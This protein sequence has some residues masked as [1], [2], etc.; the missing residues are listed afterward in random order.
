MKEGELGYYMTGFYHAIVRIEE[1]LHISNKK[2]F[3]KYVE[4][5]IANAKKTVTDEEWKEMRMEVA[6]VISAQIFGKEKS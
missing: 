6:D 1:L 5:M 4:I 2:D 3:R